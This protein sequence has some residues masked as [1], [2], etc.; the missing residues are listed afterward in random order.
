[1]LLPEEV[2]MGTGQAGTTMT[3]A[4]PPILTRDTV[5]TT[6]DLERRWGSPGLLPT[7]RVHLPWSVLTMKQTK[8]KRDTGKLGEGFGMSIMLMV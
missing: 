2:G 1:M 6:R 7:L 5:G 3:S 4:V 8:Q